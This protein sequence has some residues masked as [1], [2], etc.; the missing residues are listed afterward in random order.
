VTLVSPVGE[1][2]L[3]VNSAVMERSEAVSGEAREASAAQV[4]AE[5]LAVAVSQ[6]G[7]SEQY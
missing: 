5:A 7:R 3:V 1:A 2:L 6:A 4:A